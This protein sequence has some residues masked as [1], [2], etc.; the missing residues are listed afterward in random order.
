MQKQIEAD[1]QEI[2]KRLRQLE[3]TYNPRDEN[4]H[5]GPVDQADA[6]LYVV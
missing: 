1:F 6:N 4:L 2:H 3:K 5:F